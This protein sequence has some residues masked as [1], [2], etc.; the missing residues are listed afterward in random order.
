MS[1]SFNQN[2]RKYYSFIY[3][4]TI[5]NF[6]N[7]I[8]IGDVSND[9]KNI[10]EKVEKFKSIK[11]LTVAEKHKL[12]EYFGKDCFENLNLSNREYNKIYFN[13]YFIINEDDTIETI[14][15]KIIISLYDLGIDVDINSILLWTFDFKDLNILNFDLYHNKNK[16]P[17]LN[18]TPFIEVNKFLKNIKQNYKSLNFIMFF[19]YILHYFYKMFL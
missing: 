4:K 14:C 18:E 10:V 6:Y 12:Q 5:N 16:I 15:Y 1:N 13:K 19:L 8:F 7:I 17:M 11:Y 3:Q 9:I 2:N